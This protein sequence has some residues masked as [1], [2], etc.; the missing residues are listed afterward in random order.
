V[1]VEA[2]HESR[3]DVEFLPKIGQW[4]KG[5]DSLDDTANSEQ[6]RNFPKH[7]QT[8]HI[9]TESGMP[10]QLSYVEKISCPAAKIEDALGTGQIEF[11]LPNSTNVDPNPAIEIKILRPVCAGVA[12]R[13]SHANLLESDRIDCLDDPLLIK[14]KSSRSEKSER[15]FSRADQ[16][17]TI[18]KLAY[19]VSKS[20]LKIDHS[21]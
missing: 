5:I 14:R 16:A 3:N 11:N 9:K 10:Q 7:R 19:F 8:I 1:V 13:I 2:N 17:S 4:P 15:V 6:P 18:N 12:Y 20:H 21:L